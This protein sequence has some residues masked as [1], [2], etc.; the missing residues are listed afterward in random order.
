MNEKILVVDDEKDFMLLMVRHLER[1]GYNALGATD[2]LHALEIFKKE[3]D[4]I[5]IVTDWMMPVMSGNDFILRAQEIDPMIQAIII[6]SAGESLR[7][8]T[9]LPGWGNFRHLTKPLEK[10]SD[11]SKAVQFAIDFRSK[12]N[13]E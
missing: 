3:G 1:N 8:P 4:F 13:S 2:P 9:G 12:L 10:M 5:V 11:L 7:P 6:T